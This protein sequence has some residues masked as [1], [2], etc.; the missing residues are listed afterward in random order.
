MDIPANRGWGVGYKEPDL[1][2][3][4]A[5]DVSSDTKSVGE[6]FRAILSFQSFFTYLVDFRGPAWVHEVITNI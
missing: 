3:G 6:N 1:R 2:L 5:S 4:A